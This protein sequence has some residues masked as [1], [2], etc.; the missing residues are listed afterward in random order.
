MKLTAYVHL[1]EFNKI[2]ISGFEHLGQPNSICIGQV[3]I[4]FPDSD[5]EKYKLKLQEKMFQQK[6]EKIKLDFEND[7]QRI[8]GELSLVER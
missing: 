1:N 2:W 3:A 6:L 4:D 7:K 8:I 5:V